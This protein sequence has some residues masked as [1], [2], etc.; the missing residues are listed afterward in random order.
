MS[1]YLNEL[2]RRFWRLTMLGLERGPHMT[3][4][5]MYNRLRELGVRM[6]PLTGDVLCISHSTNL[7]PMLGVKPKSVREANYP[8]C[9]ITK[10]PFPDNEFD[11]VMS[12]QVLEHVEGDPQVAIDETRRV[13][14]PGGIALHTTVFMYPVHGSPGDFWRY[15]PDALRYLCRDFSEIIEADG[16]GS[17]NAWLW[18]MRGMQWEP[19]PHAKWH[20]FHKVAVKNDPAWP[21]VVWV[22]ARK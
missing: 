11:L 18:G 21:M 9:S 14:R 8:E 19:V 12:D 10:L 7:L 15:T 6:Q 13:L 20:P 3:R 22:A 4:Y 16:W 5:T 17:F 2:T 1:E